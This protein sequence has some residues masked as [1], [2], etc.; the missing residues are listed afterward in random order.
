[1]YT[2]QFAAAPFGAGLQEMHVIG[3]SHQCWSCAVVMKH[4]TTHMLLLQTAASAVVAAA[5]R[6]CHNTVRPPCLT[7]LLNGSRKRHS[8]AFPEAGDILLSL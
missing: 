5:E 8:T 6:S 4:T 7:G 3:A 2:P 1:M